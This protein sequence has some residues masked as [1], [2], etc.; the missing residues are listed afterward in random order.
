MDKAALNSLSILE[1]LEN[2]NRLLLAVE[3]LDFLYEDLMTEQTELASTNEMLNATARQLTPPP[4]PSPSILDRLKT[5]MQSLWQ[6]VSRNQQANDLRD[7]LIEKPS[8]GDGHAKLEGFLSSSSTLSTELHESFANFPQQEDAPRRKEHS[9]FE[10]FPI[11]LSFDRDSEATEEKRED[12]AR[13]YKK[14]LQPKESDGRASKKKLSKRTKAYK[15]D[16]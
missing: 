2:K 12:E 8:D 1:L 9:K 13:L 3:E 5:S 6:S 11:I 7:L 10:D 16:L 4:P 15:I 14:H